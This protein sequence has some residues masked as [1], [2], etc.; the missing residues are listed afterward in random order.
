MWQMGKARS[1]V[2]CLELTSV[3]VFPLYQIWPPVHCLPSFAAMVSWLEL[4]SLLYF[5]M[6]MWEMQK[7]IKSLL[8]FRIGPTP[9]ASSMS[10]RTLPNK[11]KRL[12]VI[13]LPKQLHMLIANCLGVFD[14]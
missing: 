13:T 8:Y 2:K 1:S 9:L 3:R 7:K 10:T 11:P 6:A 12:P 4:C 5:G 14:I